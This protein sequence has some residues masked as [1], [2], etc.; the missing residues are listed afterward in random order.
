MTTEKEDE[1]YGGV[2]KKRNACTGPSIM[3]AL[4]GTEI[5]LFS[6][7]IFVPNFS[8]GGKNN[9]GTLIC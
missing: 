7:Y 4:S 3:A 6:K 1:E 5:T 2:A 8:E 9:N